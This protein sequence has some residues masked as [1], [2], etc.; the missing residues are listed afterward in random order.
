MEFI[1]SQPAPLN[2]VEYLSRLSLGITN[3]VREEY[4][5]ITC[6]EGVRERTAHWRWYFGHFHMDEALWKNQFVLPDHVRRL[7]TGDVIGRRRHP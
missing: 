1:V 5:L 4:S 2:T 6:L 3:Q 7:E